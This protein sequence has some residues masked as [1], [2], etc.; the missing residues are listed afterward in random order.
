MTWRETGNDVFIQI[1]HIVKER[2]QHVATRK[3]SRGSGLHLEDGGQELGQRRR[4][5]C[6]GVQT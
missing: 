5:L 4:G 3:G 6:E 1:K 2:L